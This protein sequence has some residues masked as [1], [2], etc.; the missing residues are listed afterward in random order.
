MSDK[1]KRMDPVVHFEMPAQDR[2]R[3]ATFYETTFG[4]KTIMLKEDMMDYVLVRTTE[5]SEDG[6]PER[7]GA[8]NGGFYPTKPDWPAQYPAV[9]IAVEDIEASMQKVTA[10]GGKVLDKPM[11]I[12]GFGLYVAFIDTEGNRASMMQPTSEWQEK[13]KS[14]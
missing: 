5:S 13:T 2:K 8:I 4:W 10:S 9:V 14:E 3:M 11:E 12:P 7:V 1:S 6:V